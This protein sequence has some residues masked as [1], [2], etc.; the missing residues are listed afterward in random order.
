MSNVAILLRDIIFLN[1]INE[2]WNHNCNNRTL[3]AIDN[4][5]KYTILKNIN[6]ENNIFLVF[7]IIDIL[8]FKKKV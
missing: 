1:D 3:L 2:F 5:S 8:I 6:K 4:D 7:D